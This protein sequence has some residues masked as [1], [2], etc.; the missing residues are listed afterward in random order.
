MVI[1]SILRT[2]VENDDIKVDSGSCFGIV[3]L[4]MLELVRLWTH[5]SPCIIMASC[6][7]NGG[8][9]GLKFGTPGKNVATVPCA[10]HDQRRVRSQYSC[11]LF[12]AIL[13]LSISPTRY[14]L[15]PCGD[16][17]GDISSGE[18]Y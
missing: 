18:A 13:V 6:C 3:P 4:G 7:G 12:Q 8:S 5:K 2:L 10:V 17:P 14:M 16:C 1:E 11:R 15:S 9:E